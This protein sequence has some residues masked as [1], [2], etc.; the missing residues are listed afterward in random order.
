MI[1][2]RYSDAEWRAIEQCLRKVTNEPASWRLPLEFLIELYL[3]VLRRTDP[4]S[5]EAAT[6]RDCWNAISEHVRGLRL[7]FDKLAI[8]QWPCSEL[9]AWQSAVMTMAARAAD[10]LASFEKTHSNRARGDNVNTLIKD[11]LAFWRARGGHVGRSANSPSTGFVMAAAG[12]VLANTVPKIRLQ[13][14]VIA[15]ARGC[16]WS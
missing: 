15:I 11:L 13:S 6:A 3:G 10:E 7:Q 12:K 1:E 4:R 16:K 8:L 9:P 14:A 2:F 5:L